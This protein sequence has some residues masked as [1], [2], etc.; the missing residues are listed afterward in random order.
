MSERPLQPPHLLERERRNEDDA[1]DEARQRE[2]EEEM[3]RDELRQE[4]EDRAV[5]AAVIILGVSGETASAA[6]HVLYRLGVMDGVLRASRE[7][8]L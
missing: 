2:L 1:Y 6:L 3:I 7:A 8:M 4:A 5:A